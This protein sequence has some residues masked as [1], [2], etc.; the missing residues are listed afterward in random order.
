MRTAAKHRQRLAAEL[1]RPDW[2]VGEHAGAD[3]LNTV[4]ARGYANEIDHL[5]DY[6]DLLRWMGRAGLVSVPEQRQLA[7][8]ATGSV[9]HRVLADAK[10][11][12]GAAH[13]IIQNR[14]RGEKP[15]PQDLAV[16]RS[17]IDGAQRARDLVWNG[18][19]LDHTWRNPK[20]VSL[21][22]H[23]LALE[24]ADL[25]RSENLSRVHICQGEECDWAFLDK[26]PS[27]R[28]RWCHMSACGNRAKV[29]NMRARKRRA[30]R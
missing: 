28:R 25:F 27:Q 21:P 17:A 11:L 12:R 26:S 5:A 16:V 23:V 2:M 24:I 18:H 29:R 15:R 4:D 1:K 6:D 30:K 22:V 10:A 7:G 3:F 8:R 14:S 19:G 13:A 20:D 9:A